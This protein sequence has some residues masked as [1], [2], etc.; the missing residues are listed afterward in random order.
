MFFATIQGLD[1]ALLAFETG[2]NNDD[3]RVMRQVVSNELGGGGGWLAVGQH[4][5]IGNNNNNNQQ[6]RE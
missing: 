1:A 6:I 2:R 4:I 5:H 3:F